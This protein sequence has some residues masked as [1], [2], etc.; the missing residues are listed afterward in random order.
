MSIAYLDYNATCPPRPEVAEA[1]IAALRLGANASSVHRPGRTA[2]RVL[3]SAREAVGALAGVAPERVVFT[4]GGTEANNQALRMAGARGSLVSA[5]EHASVLEAAPGACR[6]P[7]DRDGCLDLQA[8]EELIRRHRPGLVSVML[9]NNETGVIQPVAEVA[10]LAHAVDALVHCDAVQAPGR[11]DLDQGALGV[12]LM[13]LS[14]H[15]L[16]GPQGAGALV[17]GPE[18]R[19]EALL[20]GGGQERRQRAGTENLPGIAGFGRA[21]ELLLEDGPENGHER[22]RIEALRDRLEAGVLANAPQ[23]DIF[24]QGAARAPNT[25]CIAM[26]GVSNEIQLMAF[27][28]DGIAVSTGSACS[29][30]K[31]GPSH[32]LAAMGVPPAIAACAIRVT[33]GFAS[34]A[35]EVDRFVGA[36]TRLYARSGGGPTWQRRIA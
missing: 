17:L 14:A 22:A 12:D 34:T 35:D 33:L 20:V 28:L 29:S 4:S 27:D 16:G 25:T 8:A 31:V 19:P 24:G 6:L 23:A 30:G 5:V 9:V 11:I 2:R 15:K 18:V 1:V 13:T 10:R 7:V 3:E 26:P 36:W 32:V 21:A